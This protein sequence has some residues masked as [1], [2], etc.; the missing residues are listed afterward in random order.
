MYCTRAAAPGLSIEEAAERL[1]L[2]VATDEGRRSLSKAWRKRRGQ[3][4]PKPDFNH[5]VRAIG[6][7]GRGRQLP[8]N[9]G[10]ELRQ[11]A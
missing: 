5:A 1:G 9:S 4:Q 7:L 6:N 10:T 2:S 8:T 11:S 3:R